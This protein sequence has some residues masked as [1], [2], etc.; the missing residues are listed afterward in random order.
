MSITSLQNLWDDF[1]MNYA[2]SVLDSCD[3]SA[4][5]S[6]PFMHSMTSIL[7]IG[8]EMSGSQNMQTVGRVTQAYSTAMLSLTLIF[9]AFDSVYTNSL[10][11]M[12]G[13]TVSALPMAIPL[14][15]RGIRLLSKVDNKFSGFDRHY[16]IAMKVINLSTAVFAMTI[17][18]SLNVTV[19]M[20]TFAFYGLSV[21]VNGIALRKTLCLSSSF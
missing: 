11:E 4:I 14:I 17:A 7:G 15:T 12:T 3:G 8:L 6:P 10:C 13:L 2:C 18:L 5:G 1:P 21:L 9:T 16:A 20:S 19:P